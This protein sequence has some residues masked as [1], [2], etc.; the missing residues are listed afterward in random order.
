MKLT[1]NVEKVSSANTSNLI[2]TAFFYLKELDYS[3]VSNTNNIIVFQRGG[4][5]DLVPRGRNMNKIKDGIFEF[6]NGANENI[7][8][9]TYSISI[10]SQLIFIPVLLIAGVFKGPIMFVGIVSLIICTVAFFVTKTKAEEMITEIRN[11]A[12]IEKEK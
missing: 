5:I 3:I 11:R 7:I 4:G 8:K 9:L 10:T 6:K 12:E 1:Y 2:N